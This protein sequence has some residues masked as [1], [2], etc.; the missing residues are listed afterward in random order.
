MASDKLISDSSL[1]Q[2]IKQNIYDDN[3]ISNICDVIDGEP[4]IPS[5]PLRLSDWNS[6]Y[7]V[8]LPKDGQKILVI[9]TQ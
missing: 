8:P 9:D 4:A 6:F 3:L 2:Y 5:L 7:G 1:K